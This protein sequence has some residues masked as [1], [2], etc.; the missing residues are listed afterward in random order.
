MQEMACLVPA[1]ERGRRK[2]M[3]LTRLTIRI[4]NPTDLR[5]FQDVEC[6][7]DSGAMYTVIPKKILQE[8]GISPHSKRSFRLANGDKMVRELGSADV[9]Y[10]KRHGAATV[11]FGE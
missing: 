3:G 6:L 9:I 2:H 4:A 11:L 7:I 10:E 1:D 5:R 8:I